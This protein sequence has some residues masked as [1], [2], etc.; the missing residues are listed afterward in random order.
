[1][2]SFGTASSIEHL[3]RV[4]SAAKEKLE[5][6]RYLLELY[7]KRYYLGR[8]APLSCCAG[9]EELEAAAPPPPPDPEDDPEE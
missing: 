7:G 3:S 2:S 9:A 8:D 6:A 1:M 5:R 4:L